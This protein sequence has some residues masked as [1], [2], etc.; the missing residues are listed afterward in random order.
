[1]A[2]NKGRQNK[3]MYGRNYYVYLMT[4][5][6]NTV[7]YTGVTNN[8]VRRVYE[9]K[10]KLVKGFTSQY[11]IC[12]LVYFEETSDINEAIRREKQIKGWLRI[13]KIKLIEIENHEWQDLSEEWY[14]RDPSPSLRSGSG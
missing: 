3:S 13:K 4:N 10:N 14:S 1:M 6:T 9:H 7:I 11:N 2:E 8:L 5:K 12:K